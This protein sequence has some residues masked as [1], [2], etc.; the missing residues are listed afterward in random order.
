M[1]SS[2]GALLRNRGAVIG[3]PRP[4]RRRSPSRSSRRSVPELAL[5]PRRPPLLAP[6]AMERLPARHRR[7]RPRRRS[8][9]HARRARLAPRSASSR[10]RSRSSSAC[11]SARSRAISAARVDDALMRFTE[12]FQTVPSF[13]LAV[14][15]VAILQPSIA[16]IVIA[17][18]LVS[19]PPVARLV[20]GEVLRCARANTSRPRSRSARRTPRIILD[21]GAAQH[22]R[23]DHRDGLAHGGDRDPARILALLPRPRRSE[24]DDLGLH[25]RRR[26]HAAPRRVVDLLLPRPRDLP[27][28]AG[29]E[30]RRRGPERRA[31]PAPR[32][33]GAS[34]PDP[35]LA[36]ERLTL[37]PAAGQRTGRTR[38]RT[39]SL[40]LD[41]RRDP[42]RRRRVRARAS[43]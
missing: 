39:S 21:P 3:A 28:R 27:H 23:P 2:C 24:P 20:R 16:S 9:A 17:I 32:A 38:S 22:R 41:A 26:P 37:A 19:W 18:A 15:I 6:F 30:P 5:A 7:A 36:I 29:A 13:A 14:V 1:T 43:R 4:P 12:F 11:R 8:P 10:R 31:Q 42:L 25:G 35:V 33:R 40:A 34:V